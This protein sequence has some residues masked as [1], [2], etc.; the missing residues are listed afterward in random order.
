MY[1]PHTHTITTKK[2]TAQGQE[3]SFEGEGYVYYVNR[4]DGLTG[5]CICL[6]SS[7]CIH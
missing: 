7:S 6:N 4:S 3:E 2:N 5:I 1:L